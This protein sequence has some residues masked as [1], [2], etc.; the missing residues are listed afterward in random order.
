MLAWPT[1]TACSVFDTLPPQL[2]ATTITR[3]VRN[4]RWENP[5]FLTEATGAYGDNDP[6]DACVVGTANAT[7]GAVMQC[8][9]LGVYAMIDDGET[10]WKL[11]L[12]PID[13]PLAATVNELEDLQRE[14]PGLVYHM[15]DWL[16]TY[17]MPDGKPANKFGFDQQCKGREYALSVIEETAEQWQKLIM[18]EVPPMV[19]GKYDLSKG[20]ANTTVEGSPYRVS[21]EEA[22]KLLGDATGAVDAVAVPSRPLAKAALQSGTPVAEQ[23]QLSQLADPHSVPGLPDAVGAI[24][25]ACQAAAAEMDGPDASPAALAKLS[26]AVAAAVA[27]HACLVADTTSGAVA[28]GDQEKCFVAA[29]AATAGEQTTSVSFGL[30]HRRSEPIHAVSTAETD[31]A[32][33]DMA[34]LAAGG[35]V[36]FSRETLMYFTSGYKMNAFRLVKGEGFNYSDSRKW[37][38]T[39]IGQPGKSDSLGMD[40]DSALKTGSPLKR[41]AALNTASEAL[42]VGA[43]LRAANADASAYAGLKVTL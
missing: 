34:G 2:N 17:K 15:Y 29:V 7:R 24:A 9:V 12:L 20:L 1:H 5:T 8:K 10:D 33:Q 37:P 23:I 16:R 41:D 31:L 11:V 19:E 39:S 26:A 30:Y 35:V 21:V 38:A 14:A 28:V 13:D 25:A 6:L 42:P 22:R 3:T 18:G 43:L 32:G 4:R 40:F 27:P 36:L